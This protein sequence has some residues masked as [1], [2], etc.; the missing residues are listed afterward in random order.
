MMGGGGGINIEKNKETED[1]FVKKD[2]C[3][4]PE[5]GDHKRGATKK[6]K[7][8]NFFRNHSRIF[9]ASSYLV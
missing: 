8:D 3:T 6:N 2:K 1:V 7:R 5:L 4:K 9:G